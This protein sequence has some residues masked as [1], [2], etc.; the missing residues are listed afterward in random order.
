MLHR[1]GAEVTLVVAT[2]GEAAYPAMDADQRRA[3]GRARRTELVAALAVQGLDDVPVHWLG[4]PDSGLAD[5]ADDLRDA[6]VPLLAG[7]DA[8]LAPWPGDP[9]PDHRAAGQAAAAAAPATTHG[10]SYPIWMWARMTP[11]DPAIPWIRAHLIEIDDAARR[12]KRDAIGCFASQVMHGPNGEPPVLPADVLAHAARGEEL[13]FREPRSASAPVE[14]F[15]E[16][17]ADGNDPWRA[18][19]WYERRKR[20]VVLASLPRERYRTVFE[21]GCGTGDLS[22]ELARRCTRLLASDPVPAAVDRAKAATATQPGVKIDCDALPEAV[23]DERIDLA[24]FSEVL[25]YLDDDALDETLRRTVAVL[26]PGGDLLVVH[27]R[28]WPAEAPRDAMATHAVVRGRPEL[29]PLV[30]HIDEDF[31]VLVLRRR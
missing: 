2:D 6:L 23:P 3:L 13:L 11:D 29:E 20:A 19:S 16:L 28:G 17:Y 5:H 7:A 14:R 15:A 10:W 31:V 21:P 4:L 27:W 9:H 12:A 1:G 8:Y 25:Y 26:E 24:V 22:V 30:E 18:D